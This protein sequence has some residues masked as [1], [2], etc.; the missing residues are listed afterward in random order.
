MLKSRVFRL[1]F[2]VFSCQ[3]RYSLQFTVPRQPLPVC[4]L[5]S[6]SGRLWS[7]SRRAEDAGLD[8]SKLTTE[9][10]AQKCAISSEIPRR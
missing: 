4:A 9:N 5:Q 10:P 1:Q 7:L 3:F 2:S 8:N 6:G